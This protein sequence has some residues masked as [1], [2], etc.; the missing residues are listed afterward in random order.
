MTLI[1]DTEVATSV[2]AA[3]ARRRSGR[4]DGRTAFFFLL[5]SLLGVLL[6]LV[7]P[8]IASLA[9]SFTNWKLLGKPAFV[10]IQ[11]YVRLFTADPQFWTVLRNTL[12]FTV[13]YLVLNI[14]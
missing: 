2:P 12:F 14:I 4:D 9:L 10:G 5:P 7:L 11:N 3:R 1:Q 8:I 6:F 13:E